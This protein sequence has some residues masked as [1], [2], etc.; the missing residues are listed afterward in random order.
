[1]TAVPLSITQRRRF[2]GLLGAGLPAT[3][4]LR[5]LSAATRGKGLVHSQTSTASSRILLFGVEYFN[6]V[7]VEQPWHATGLAET[8]T[9]LNSQSP[10]CKLHRPT[11]RAELMVT[12]RL[13]PGAAGLFAR[14]WWVFLLR[15]LLALFLGIK[16]LRQ[17]FLPLG[18]LVLGF[19]IYAIFEGVSALLAVVLGWSY[20]R[21]RWFLLLEA[22]AG[23]GLGILTLLRPAMTALVLIF[24]IAAWALPTGFLRIVEAVNLD[25]GSGR[26]WL[27]VSGVTSIIF[28]LLVLFRPLTGAQP[29]ATL[30]GIYGSILGV[31][32]IGLAVRLNLGRSAGRQPAY[33]R[34]V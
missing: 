27:V 34:A 14:S 7:G 16:V 9:T 11:Q 30:I 32:E 4:G 29:M 17:P 2:L 20:H 25:E 1:M 15:G 31:T 26:G 22:V 12:D 13:N 19:A 10:N 24:F 6:S 23:I 18:L 33:P 8:P 3:L 5:A 21:G 28:A